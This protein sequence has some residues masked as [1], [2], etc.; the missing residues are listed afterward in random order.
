MLSGLCMPW[1]L[2]LVSGCI[3]IGGGDV[4]PTLYYT[5]EPVESSSDIE[6]IETGGLVV[7]LERVEVPDHL[8]R[9]E[10]VVRTRPNEL[11]YTANHLWAERLGTSLPRILTQDMVRQIN[12]PVRVYSL[13]WPDEV[14]P[15]LTVLLEIHAFE[16]QQSP[17]SMVLLDI[18]WSIRSLPDG[19][20][21][22]QGNHRGKDLN[23]DGGNYAHLA[24][25]LSD[26]L[27]WVA[28][29]IGSDI[30]VINDTFVK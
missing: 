17:D 29:L 20:V 26:E 18:S 5:L 16:A 14:V 19:D 21:L 8:D 28:R 27:A 7:G 11:R 30:A 23:W 24:E 3:G 1:I 25:T 6:P 12:G 13:P 9:K 15:D 22:K 4:E 2:L 10:I